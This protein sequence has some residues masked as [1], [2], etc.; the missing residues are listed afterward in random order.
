MSRPTIIKFFLS[1]IILLLLVFLIYY[2]YQTQT[3]SIYS[4]RYEYKS[5][6][7][8]EQ[9]K[10]VNIPFHVVDV[11]TKQ[12]IDGVSISLEKIRFCPEAI[13]V[14]CPGPDYYGRS[15]ST[16]GNAVVAVNIY[17]KQMPTELRGR[18]SH[19]SYLPTDIS[20]K[21]FPDKADYQ[22]VEVQLVPVDHWKQFGWAPKGWKLGEIL[23][24]TQ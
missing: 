18:I 12:P 19:T 17:S 10:I 21:T 5:D 1:V 11:V 6:D 14:P 23:Y 8:L 13:G 2:R 20:V 16:D 24:T 22:T 4:D 15:I 7:R 9:P 3:R